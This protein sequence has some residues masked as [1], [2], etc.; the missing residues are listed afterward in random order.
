MSADAT[1]LLAQV[2]EICMSFPKAME[3][4]SHGAPAFHIDKGRVF[5]WFMEDHHRNGVI[6]IALKTSGEEEQA[7]LIEMDPETYY[8]PAYLAPFGWIGMR[9]DLGP[10]DWDHVRDKIEESWLR[11]APPKLAKAYQQ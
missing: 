5:V 9:I 1:S 8:R 10:V 3:K 2:R 11:V 4:T 6:A 7:M